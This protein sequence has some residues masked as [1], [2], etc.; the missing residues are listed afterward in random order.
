MRTA[1]GDIT[2]ETVSK[3]ADT[4]VSML[5]NALPASVADERNALAGHGTVD[6]A[7]ITAPPV[8][9]SVVSLRPLGSESR[10]AD[11]GQLQGGKP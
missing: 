11:A 1:I 5:T 9:Q 6:L 8:W 3:T 10:T 2:E 4:P 7:H